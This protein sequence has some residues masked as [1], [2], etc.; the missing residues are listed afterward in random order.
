MVFM[1]YCSQCHSLEGVDGKIMK[2]PNLGLIYN[3][4]VG[5]NA[6]YDTYTD[7]ML[8]SSLFWTPLNLYRFMAN[9]NSVIPKTSCKLAKSPLTS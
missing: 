3:R 2:G 1:K 7:N 6:N 5:S 4:R 9:A 8:K